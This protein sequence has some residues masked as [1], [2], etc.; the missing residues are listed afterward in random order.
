MICVILSPVIRSYLILKQTLI[1]K[2]FARRLLL[3]FELD[4]PA[5][6]SIVILVYRNAQ[7]YVHKENSSGATYLL[8][9]MHMRRLEHTHAHVCRRYITKLVCALY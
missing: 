2:T 3:S 6:M 1:A 4:F 9:H 8:L 5:F 7:P